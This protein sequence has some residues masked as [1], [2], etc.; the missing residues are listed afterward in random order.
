M[1]VFVLARLLKVNVGVC[2]RRLPVP[3]RAA[4]ARRTADERE[5]ER[6][7][8]DDFIKGKARCK[9]RE[10]PVSTTRRKF[11]RIGSTFLADL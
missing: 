1:A 11:G 2:A 3:S 6:G 7:N 4:P 10:D 9:G 5:R 8:D